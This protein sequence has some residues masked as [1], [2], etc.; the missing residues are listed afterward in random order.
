ML[1]FHDEVWDR[2]SNLNGD[3]INISSN[4]HYL[5]ME[6]RDVSLVVQVIFYLEDPLFPSPSIIETYFLCLFFTI[7]L[8]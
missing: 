1:S 3:Q 4:I 5:G 8:H 2:L 6:C 7:Y